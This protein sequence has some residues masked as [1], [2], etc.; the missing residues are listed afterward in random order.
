MSIGMAEQGFQGI[1]INMGCPVPNVA[2]HGKGSG[3][4]LRPT[5]AAEVIQAAKVG[6]YL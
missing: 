5:V 2:T 4:I 6:G 1:D 3:L